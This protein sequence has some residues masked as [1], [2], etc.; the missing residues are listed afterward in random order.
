MPSTITTA[1]IRRLLPHRY[2]FLMVDAVVAC[3]PGMRLVARKL[4]THDEPF[5]ASQG[6]GDP[7]MPRMRV[8]ESMA[9]A[10]GL[11]L[12]AEADA[13][14]RQVVYVASRDA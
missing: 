11:L 3:E 5:L 13:P 12:M 8:V 7:V 10:G 2:P 9:R 4:V 1:D 14:T 6:G